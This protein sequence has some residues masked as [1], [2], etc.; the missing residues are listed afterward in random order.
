VCISV[1]LLFLA[2]RLCFHVRI[3]IVSVLRYEEN[4]K[5][6]LRGIDPVL[7][8][9][10]LPEVAQSHISN[11][12]RRG[13]A[14][15]RAPNTGSEGYLD[16][17]RHNVMVIKKRVQL[18]GDSE[19]K[20]DGELTKLQE[21]LNDGYPASSARVV[22]ALSRR[23]RELQSALVE[24]TEQLEQAH[25]SIEGLRQGNAKVLELSKVSCSIL[26]QVQC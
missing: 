3:S 26:R 6:I 21:I 10:L 19:T 17:S 14:F 4:L 16:Q 11:T 8:P 5:D 20:A 15:Q 12:A 25:L 18:L 1:F 22:A 9:S 13:A 23:C 2:A 7:D 24:A